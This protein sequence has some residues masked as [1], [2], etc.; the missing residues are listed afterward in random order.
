ML[1]KFLKQT[2][3]A[4]GRALMCVMVINAAAWANDIVVGQIGPFTG[5]PS[6]DAT[7]INEGAAAYFEQV[8]KAGGI[9][10]RKISF[11]K[12]DDQF[13]PDVFKQQFE[14][15]RKRK[16][17][18][19]IS[20]IGSAALTLVTKEK[21]L[22]EAEFLIVNA[23]PGSLAFRNP[24]H[25]KLFHIRASDGDQFIQILRHSRTVGVSQQYVLYQDLP[26]GK[27]GFEF[28]RQAGPQYGYTAIQG[29]ESKHDDA[30]LAAAA[31]TTLGAL[32]QQVL[33]IGSPKFMADAVRELRKAGY[34]GSMFALSYLS[35]GLLVNVAGAEGARGVGIAQ[36]Y[37]NPVGRGMILQQ[38]FQKTMGTYAPQVKNLSAFHL[39][40]YLSAR[41]LV[42]AIRNA[43]GYVTPA[44]LSAAIKSAGEIDYG[45]FR[46][47]FSKSNSGSTWVD[48]SVMDSAGKLRY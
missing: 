15:A 5:L 47:N 36:T 9:N 45:G 44:A 11:F 39:E 20:P 31:K 25:P 35:A 10:G 29:T 7:H 30:A 37:P 28:I 46:L 1:F 33:L 14:E 22:D 17:V 19:L 13:K 6:P 34:R 18:A 27:S 3:A 48:M 43:R 12:L 8:N 40:G 4:L 21:L 41:V 24:G 26:I 42:D 2:T 38:E 23:I 32:P 16:P